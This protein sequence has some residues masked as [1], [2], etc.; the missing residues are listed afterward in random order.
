MSSGELNEIVAA[1]AFGAVLDIAITGISQML[2]SRITFM[3]LYQVSAS[4]TSST[5]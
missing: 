1:I 2:L 5:L 4:F 3:D